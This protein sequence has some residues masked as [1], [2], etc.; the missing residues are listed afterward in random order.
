MNILGPLAA[1]VVDQF[2]LILEDKS[3]LENGHSKKS[4]HK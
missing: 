1:K 4:N 3:I 2:F